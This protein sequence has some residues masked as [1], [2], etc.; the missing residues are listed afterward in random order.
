VNNRLA[1]SNCLGRFR[2]LQRPLRLHRV[3]RRQHVAF[4]QGWLDHGRGFWRLRLRQRGPRKQRPL[5]SPAAIIPA[6]A[7]PRPEA[8]HVE[9]ILAF[10]GVA[11]L[12]LD[13]RL[14]FGLANGAG[15][16][17]SEAH[18][19]ECNLN[20]L[21]RQAL[22]RGVFHRKRKSRS[23]LQRKRRNNKNNNNKNNNKINVVVVVVVVFPYDKD[24]DENYNERFITR[25]R[26]KTPWNHKRQLRAGSKGN[27]S[28]EQPQNQAQNLACRIGKARPGPEWERKNGNRG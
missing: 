7:F 5:L 4:E 11:D 9:N 1:F 28:D 6:V 2:V 27:F 24:K 17:G 23:P 25:R 16:F 14:E 3:F 12:P 15:A 13:D 22:F 26:A 19:S 20:W 18:A 8:A 21:P 10:S